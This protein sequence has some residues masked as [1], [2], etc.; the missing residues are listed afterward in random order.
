MNAEILSPAGKFEAL[1]AAVRCGANAVYFGLGEFNAR[2]NAENFSDE[3]AKNAISLCHSVGVKSYITMNTLISD[4]EIV[5]AVETLKRICSY[6]TDALILQDIGF[7]SLVRKYAPDVLMHAST[8]MSVQTAYGM[9]MLK[10]MGFVRAVLPRE[11][12]LR[13]IKEIRRR[14]DI[15]LEH[16]VH[17]A[18]CM[19]VSGQCYLS[20]MLGSRSGNRGLCAQPC[21]LP[22]KAENGTGHDLSLKDLSLIDELKTLSDAGVC[23][24]KIEGRMKRPEYVAAAV[25]ACKNACEGEKD[26]NV[27]SSQRVTLK[28]SSVGIC[29]VSVRKKMSPPQRRYYLIFSGSMTEK[30]RLYPSAFVFLLSKTKRFLFPLRREERAFM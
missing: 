1:L 3:E 5:K 10:E 2:K 25:T 9:N 16:F 18:L 13:E 28:K 19:C 21:R 26:E 7:S 17:G 20:A 22:F 8:Q 11:T 6:N 12:S 14:T 24:F 29:S 4:D 23:S 30:H 15:E 27:T